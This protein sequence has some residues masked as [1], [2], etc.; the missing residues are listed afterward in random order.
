[1]GPSQEDTSEPPFSIP[2][3]SL[4]GSNWVTFKT[5]FLFAMGS[6]NIKGHFHGSETP[7]THPT[8]RSPDEMR[9]TAADKELNS[10]YLVVVRKWQRDE[11]I[12]CAQ[13]AQVISDS[14]IICIQHAKGIVNMWGAIITEFNKKGHMI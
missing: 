9:W 14:L 5:H 12:T 6:C 7:P 11:K 4:D 8:L 10:A 2:K 13:L 3:L 1:M